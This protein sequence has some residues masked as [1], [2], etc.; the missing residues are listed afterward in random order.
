M[1]LSGAYVSIILAYYIFRL[2]GDDHLRTFPHNF[3]QIKLSIFVVY[4]Y[5]KFLET[6]MKMLAVILRK[7]L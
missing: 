3:F 7:I 2:G 4:K 1:T 5:I 6:E